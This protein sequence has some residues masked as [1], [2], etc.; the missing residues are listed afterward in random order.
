MFIQIIGCNVKKYAAKTADEPILLD[1]IRG[2]FTGPHHAGMAS[3]QL[4]AVA[5]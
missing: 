5:L 1:F 4:L 3:R 2:L